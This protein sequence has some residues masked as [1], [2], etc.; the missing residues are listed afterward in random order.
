MIGNNEQY[1]LFDN[2]PLTRQL[3]QEG[4]QQ[5]EESA[6]DTWLDEAEGLFEEFVRTNPEKEFL[7]A[8]VNRW[9]STERNFESKPGGKAWGGVVRRILGR[10]LIVETRKVK[11]PHA[12]GSFVSVWKAAQGVSVSHESGT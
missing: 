9:A 1:S 12:H 8:Q 4:I 10:R 2:E 11:S 5:A 3:T 6:G 7:T